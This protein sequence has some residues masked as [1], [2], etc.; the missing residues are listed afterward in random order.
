MRGKNKF[1]KGGT[2]M[3]NGWGREMAHAQAHKKKKSKFFFKIFSLE[4]FTLHNFLVHRMMNQAAFDLGAFY[5][6][7]KF[8]EAS[9]DGFPHK[10]EGEEPSCEASRKLCVQ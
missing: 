10:S 4:I 9:Q 1:E 8:L 2:G 6:T 7:Q 5:H 3:E